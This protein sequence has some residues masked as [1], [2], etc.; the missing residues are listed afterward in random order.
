MNLED[1]KKTDSKEMYKT[2]DEWPEIAKNS[3]NKKFEKLD[4]KNIDHVVFAGMGG[5][6]S[7]G[8]TISA[9]LSK[10]DIHVSNVKGYL[11]PK[12]VDSNSLVIA[13]SVSGNTDET[14]E[15]LKTVKE[16]DARTI[17]FSSGGLME[18][19]CKNND[20]FFQ[21]ISMIHSPRASFTRFLYSILNILDSILPLKSKDI[22]ESI[23]SL[24]KLKGN[25]FSG[26]LTEQN[27][28][29]ELAEFT[30]DIVTI[31]Y[32]AGLQAS[33]IRYKNCLQENSKMHA[34]TEDIIESSHNGIVSWERDN[35]VKPV[36]IQGRDDH[37]K[38]L[39]RWNI[40]EDFL[41]MKKIEY[42]R[43][44]SIEGNILSKIVNLNYLLDYSSIYT[45]V[46]NKIDPSPVK[47]IEYMKNKLQ[48]K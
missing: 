13:T 40:L 30:R 48:H 29:L 14:L 46:L 22:I 19:Y 3:F 17:G 9:I 35:N 28:A 7:I 23:T 5:S 43:I 36:L 45:A 38:T 34:M 8:D 37:I 21:K 1:L 20:I 42:M 44:Q 24:E 25:I 16:T 26:N 31:Y 15:V 47:S 39:E 27:K 11:L 10:K 6:G 33:A 41:N 2:Y 32:P 12:T 4:I 18:K